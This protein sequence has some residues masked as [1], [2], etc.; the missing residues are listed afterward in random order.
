MLYLYYIS[1]QKNTDQYYHIH[2]DRLMYFTGFISETECDKKKFKKNFK[3]NIII[4]SK[5]ILNNSDSFS[6]NKNRSTSF[7]DAFRPTNSFGQI[8]SDLA[9]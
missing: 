8:A 6:Q 1:A 4:F 5:R 9:K 3:K 2:K 7:F